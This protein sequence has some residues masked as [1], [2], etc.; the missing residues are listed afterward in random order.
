MAGYTVWF[1]TSYARNCML[2]YKHIW[3]Y[4]LTTSTIFDVQ[5]QIFL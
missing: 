4:N 3:S 2:Q 5:R 1:V